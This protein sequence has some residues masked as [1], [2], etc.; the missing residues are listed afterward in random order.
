MRFGEF[1]ISLPKH[2][3]DGICHRFCC[4]LVLDDQLAMNHTGLSILHSDPTNH[5]STIYSHL[6]EQ[7]GRHTSQPPEL[8]KAVPKVGGL[9]DEMIRFAVMDKYTAAK[10]SGILPSMA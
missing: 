9:I 8:R 4:S 10:T 7:G 3:E 2:R 6:T 5:T 1:I